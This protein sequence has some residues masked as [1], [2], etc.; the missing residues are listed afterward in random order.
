MS[1]KYFLRTTL[2]DLLWSQLRDS[3]LTMNLKKMQSCIMQ[4]D[5]GNHKKEGPL[6]DRESVWSKRYGNNHWIEVSLA[7]WESG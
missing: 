2:A 7:G 1:Q 5:E 4:N 3:I 6:A